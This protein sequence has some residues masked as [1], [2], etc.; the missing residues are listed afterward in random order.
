MRIKALER[1]QKKSESNMDTG[2]NSKETSP[3][4]SGF[5]K[6]CFTIKLVF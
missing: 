3:C 1:K 5:L 4:N 6:A 2:G